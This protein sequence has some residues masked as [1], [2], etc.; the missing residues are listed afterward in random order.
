MTLPFGSAV[1][2]AAAAAAGFSLFFILYDFDNHSRYCRRDD[3]AYNQIRHL[4]YPLL[5]L[6]IDSIY[7]YL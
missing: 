5:Y 1:T 4:I 7:S 3:H 6:D 2:A